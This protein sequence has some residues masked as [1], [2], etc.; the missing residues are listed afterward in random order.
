[1]MIYF[2]IVYERNYQIRLWIK[3]AVASEEQMKH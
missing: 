1:M 2:Q 3:Y